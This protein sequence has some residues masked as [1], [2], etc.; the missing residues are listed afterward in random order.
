MKLLIIYV[1]I[2]V[3]GPRGVGRGGGGGGG[4]MP[5]I[6]SG[7]GVEKGHIFWPHLAYPLLSNISW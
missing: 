1:I 7:Q 2:Y 3:R 5:P 6:K 4:V